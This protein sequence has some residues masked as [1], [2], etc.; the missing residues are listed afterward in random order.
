M[1]GA[2]ERYARDANGV[3]AEELQHCL[4]A[5]RSGHGLPEILQAMSK[6]TAHTDA[7]RLYSLLANAHQAGG[8]P[9]RRPHRAGR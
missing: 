2:I 7:G 6:R 3:A 5:Y 4:E 9:R 1:A 8:A